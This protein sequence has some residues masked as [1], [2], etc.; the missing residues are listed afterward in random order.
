M[1]NTLQFRQGD[2]GFVVGPIPATAKRIPTR[3]FALGEITGHSHRVLPALEECVEMYEGT[4]GETY[5]RILPGAD[6]PVLHEDRDPTGMKSL[7]PAGW[8]GRVVIAAEYDEE[9]GFRTVID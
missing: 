5:V 3:P 8:E 4:D 7:L 9:E 1:Q 6:V 2:V